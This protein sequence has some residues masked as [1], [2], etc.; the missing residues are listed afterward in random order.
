MWAVITRVAA[1]GGVWAPVTIKAGLTYK[2]RHGEKPQMA[3]GLNLKD[4]ISS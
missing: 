1:A 2:L 4:I 3:Y